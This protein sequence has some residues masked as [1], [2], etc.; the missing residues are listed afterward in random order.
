MRNVL[1][2]LKQLQQA[3]GGRAGSNQSSRVLILVTLKFLDTRR[4]PAVLN[5]QVPG[6]FPVSRPSFERLLKGVGVL[7]LSAT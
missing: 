5:N 7:V 2:R 6:H 3:E 4:F 1:A